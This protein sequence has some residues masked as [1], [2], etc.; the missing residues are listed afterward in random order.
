MPQNLSGRNDAEQTLQ[1]A[2]DYAAHRFAVFPLHTPILQPDGKALCSCRRFDCK[3]VGKHPDG[4]IVRH[5]LL[6][7]SNDEAIVRAYWA[8]ALC[9]NVGVDPTSANVVIFDV[10]PRHDGDQSLARLEAQHA[11]LPPTWRVRTGGGG[12]HYYFA[13]PE[14]PPIRCSNGMVGPGLD[15]KAQGGS[16]VGAGSLHVSGGRYA[17]LPGHHPE[18]IPL[19]PMPDW[20][21]A[22]AR[23]DR[24][25]PSSRDWHVVASTQ[26]LEGERN[27][28]ITSFYGHLLAR[29][30]DARI[31]TELVLGW[32]HLRCSPPL[33]DDEVLR[34][35][36]SIACRELA[37][38]AHRG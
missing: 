12:D 8:F 24:G 20:L 1:H 34:I 5:G 9:A 2:L 32:N 11:P 10:D 7:A 29:N 35:C 18:D 26:V 30:V 33:S 14:G 31:A 13:R 19:A 25:A 21:A 15:I 38:R 28:A 4:R 17:W 37:R 27:S 16:V 6:D 36:A 3:N 22:L 23:V